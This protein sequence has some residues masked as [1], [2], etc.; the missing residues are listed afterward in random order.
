MTKKED[1]ELLES[2]IKQQFDMDDHG[3]YIYGLREDYATTAKEHIFI[4]NKI[5]SQIPKNYITPKD[6][7]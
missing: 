7:S 5:S 1:K 4:D 6:N 3:I 2:L